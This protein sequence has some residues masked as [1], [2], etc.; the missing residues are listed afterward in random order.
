MRALATIGLLL[1]LLPSAA[2]AQ[3]PG[4]EPALLGAGGRSRPVYTGSASQYQEP[5]PV[6]RSYG[7]VL[8]VRDTRGPLEGGV[9][10]EILPGVNA[11]LQLAYEEGRQTNESSFLIQHHLPN[12]GAGASLA[13]NWSGTST[14]APRPSTSSCAH[15]STSRPR[16]APRPTSGS[17]W[18]C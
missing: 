14:S 8:F 7:P 5:V 9:H 4:T 6:V 15:G 10:V 2:R 11:G 16:K 3:D 18:G 17:A 13:P 12:I 1:L